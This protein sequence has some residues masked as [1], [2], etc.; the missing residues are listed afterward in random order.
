ML[1]ESN[2]CF[3]VE[4]RTD[5]LDEENDDGKRRKAESIGCGIVTD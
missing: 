3:I 5:V 4:N 2:K 1:T